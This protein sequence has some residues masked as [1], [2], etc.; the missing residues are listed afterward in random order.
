M[1]RRHITAAKRAAGRTTASSSARRLRCCAACSLY[2]PTG[3]RDAFLW[4]KQLE[5]CH[6]CIA[7]P[8]MHALAR[9]R[10]LAHHVGTAFQPRDDG[11]SW[12]RKSD[13]SWPRKSDLS[14][15]RLS[16]LTSMPAQIDHH[17]SRWLLC[18]DM[19][20]RWWWWM[21]QGRSLLTGAKGLECPLVNKSQLSQGRD[22]WRY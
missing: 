12:P 5:E 22:I 8:Q 11:S 4:Q 3:L 2:Q 14:W 7:S 20:R 13:L 17:K 9:R 21:P 10:V 15:P 1:P 18:P 19:R 16:T 6:W